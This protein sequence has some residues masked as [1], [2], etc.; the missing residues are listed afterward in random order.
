[1]EEHPPSTLNRGSGEIGESG[2][3]FIVG[4]CPLVL[5]IHLLIVEVTEAMCC[6]AS[7]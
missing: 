5:E 6:S 2:S 4:N 1:M 3:K 7:D